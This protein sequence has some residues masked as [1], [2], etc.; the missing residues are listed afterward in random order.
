MDNILDKLILFHF[1]AKFEWHFFVLDMRNR[2]LAW[3]LW[4]YS[5]FAKREEGAVDM[6][7]AALFL[8]A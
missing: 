4:V 6:S 2:L 5:C 7:Q 1:Q 3:A 8:K